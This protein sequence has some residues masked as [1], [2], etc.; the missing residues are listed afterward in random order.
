MQIGSTDYRLCGLDTNVVSEIVR[1]PRTYL[2]GIVELLQDAPSLLCFSP[3]SLFELRARR[4]VFAAFVELF[5]VYPCALLKNEEQLFESEIAAYD[6][7]ER[8]D[9]FLF[10]FSYINKSRGTNLKNLLSIVFQQTAT[11]Q[12]ER[13]WP[14][15]KE[16]L[17]RDWLTLKQNYPPRGRTYLL[18]EAKE[19][20]RRATLQ[21][22]RHRA[23]A[24]VAS[25]ENRGEQIEW[26]RFP[27]VIMTLLT[28]FFRL[29]EPATRKPR[30]QDVFDVLIS[31]P[32]PYLDVVFTER[33]QAEILGKSRRIFPAISG[34][35]VFSLREIRGAADS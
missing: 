22:V 34:V 12:R 27:S 7:Q 4:D 21:Q 19:F 33:M 18:P 35:K 2:R 20:A 1:Q 13:E 29:Y 26:R 3:Y 31:T 14:A 10:G 8:V 32:T 6:S 24:W 15:F 23:P 5:D 30:V 16:E 17:L 25:V 28:V 9:P 11:L